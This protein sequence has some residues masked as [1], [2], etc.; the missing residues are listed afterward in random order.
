MP[1]KVAGIDLRLSKG[2][3]KDLGMANAPRFSVEMKP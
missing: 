3:L 1:V 2:L